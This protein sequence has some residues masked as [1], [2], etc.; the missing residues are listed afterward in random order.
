MTSPRSGSPRRSTQERRPAPV[1]FLDLA[2]KDRGERRSLLAAVGRVLDHGQIVIGPEVGRLERAIARRCRRKHAVGVNSGTDALYI[3]LSALGLGPGDEVITT[4]MS[5]I[6]TANAVRL[7][8]ATP[9]F[10]DVGEDLNLDPASAARLV[11]PRTRGI[12]VVHN[13]GKMA[14]VDALLALTRRHGLWL[15]EDGAQAF[16]ARRG[17]RV[18]GESG[19]LGC[20]SMNPMKVLAAL[21][22]AG[23]VV[24]DDDAL[25]E[26]MVALRY[27]GTVDREDCHWVSH[28]GRLDTLQAAMLL[29]RLA[30][31]DGLI[32]ARRRIARRYDEALGDLVPVPREAPGCRDVFYTYTILTE[33]R[34]AL[35]RHLA[36]R[37]IESR[38]RHPVLMPC[39]TAYREQAR[40][41]WRNAA[42]LVTQILSLPIHEKLGERAVERVIREVRR[43]LEG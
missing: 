39:H 5:W 26:R 2:V 22:E 30:R 27:N 15:V 33:R 3:G 38:V 24:T 34:D 11:G 43:F 42:R 23:M 25:Q 40:G 37:G 12:L 7:C 8:G 41:E 21:G 14:D 13:N 6:A 35:Q 10:A 32:D 28:N 19:V 16:S 18:A 9:V 29:E 17:G 31:V 1:R 4:S 20:F 36:A